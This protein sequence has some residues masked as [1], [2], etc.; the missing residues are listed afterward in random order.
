MCD[1]LA[2][3]ADLVRII[4]EL[5]QTGASI[6]SLGVSYWGVQIARGRDFWSRVKSHSG[7]S[8]DEEVVELVASSEERQI[9]FS[10]ALEQAIG[11]DWEKTRDVLARIV[12]DVLS[13]E[14]W[15][16]DEITILLRTA[17][18][19]GRN[20]VAVLTELATPRPDRYEDTHFVGAASE[21]DIASGLPA[22][23]GI[24]LPPILGMLAMQGLIVDGA[25]GTWDY[26]GPRW[27]LTPYAFRF[28]RH[29]APTG[30]IERAT[31]AVA[32]G[33]ARLYV[34][35]LGLGS[36]SVTSIEATSDGRGLLGPV[37]LPLELRAGE[38]TELPCDTNLDP[39]AG[40]RLSVRWVDGSG[41]ESTAER[42]QSRG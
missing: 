38:K 20:D 4:N 9:V 33:S 41:A 5:T 29:L 15:R 17:A 40:A 26:G 27:L 3:S 18:Q 24:L 2:V 28:F 31:F 11:S 23:T 6:G 16:L 21:A 37:T 25:L 10:S 35:N 42:Y 22:D 32:L 39:G 12:A 8:S 14:E 36:G 7:K 13:G 34:R 1:T 30:D 19:L